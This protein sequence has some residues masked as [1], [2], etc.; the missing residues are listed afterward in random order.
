MGSTVAAPTPKTP[1]KYTDLKTP[2][3]ARGHGLQQRPRASVA[4]QRRFGAVPWTTEY[5]WVANIAQV[6]VLA[7]MILYIYAEVAVF[8]PVYHANLKSTIGSWWGVPANATMGETTPGH[9][10]MIRPT[11]FFLFCVL[12]FVVSLLLV[13]F[14]KNF[15]IRRVSSQVALKIAMVLRRKPSVGN[16]ISYWSYSEW[17]F[18][19]G[20]LVAGNMVVF[21]YNYDRRL[22]STRAKMAKKGQALTFDNYLDTISITLGFSCIYNLAFLFLPAT[23]NCAWMEFFNISYA[24]GIKYHR[25]LG[26][27]TVLTA[28]GHGFGYSWMWI[29]KKQ[30]KEHALPCFDCNVGKGKGYFV[31]FNFF[32]E[33]ALLCFLLIGITSMPL[34][35]RRFYEAFYY[36][37]HLFIVGV[38]FAVMHW[39]P[40]IWWLFPT[41]LVYVMSRC[42]SH[43]NSYTPVPIHEFSYLG[44]AIIKIVIGRSTLRD[45]HFRVGQFV[46]LNVP[47]ISKL[48]WH[49]FTIASSPRSHTTTLSILAKSLGSW[50]ENLVDYAEEC[51]KQQVLPTVY[52]DAYYGASLETYEE[53]NTICLAKLSHGEALR[54]RVFFVFSFRE[55][56]LFEEIHPLLMKIKE[57]DPQKRFFRTFLYLSYAPMDELLDRPINHSRLDGRPDLQASEYAID[58]RHKS[59]EPFAEP[60]RSR[61]MRSLTYLAL[62]FVAVVA[63][64][65]LE[66][67]GKIKAGGRGQLWLLQQF[68]EIAVLFCCALVV[69][70]FLY[71]DRVHI[72]ERA[73]RAESD[74]HFVGA[75]GPSSLDVHTF[76]DLLHEHD[77][78]LGCRPDLDAVIEEVHAAHEAFAIASGHFQAKTPIGMFMSG[79]KT[80]KRSTEFAIAAINVAAFDIHE[81]EFEFPRSGAASRAREDFLVASHRPFRS[82]SWTTRHRWTANVAQFLV[83]GALIV[84][85]YAQITFVTPLYRANL[86][87]RFDRWWGVPNNATRDDQVSGHQEMIRPTYFFLFCVLPFVV[88]LLLVEFLKNFNVRRVTSGVA[89]KMARVLRRKP[90]VGSWISY[91]SYGEWAFMWGLLVAGNIIVY[92]YFFKYRAVN[93]KAK[94][95]QGMQL[96]D[97]LAALGYN[98]IYNMAFL[99]LPATRNCAWMEFFNVSYANGIK[100]HRWLGVFTVMASL[101][102]G[103]G[104]FWMWIRKG[105]LKEQALPCFDCNIATGKGF[106]AWF[107]VFGELA[108]LCFLV[109]G[110]TSMPFIRRQCYELF[111]YVHHLFI[112]GVI[113]T[114]MHWGPIIWWLLPTLLVYIMSRCTSHANSYTP[115]LINEFT[116]LHNDIVKIV[117]SRSTLRDGHFRVGQF[118]YLNVPHISKLQWHAFTIASSPRSGSTTL[119]ILA[120]SLGNW[121]KDLVEYADECKKQNTLPTVYMDAY[122][123]ASLEMYEEYNTVCLVGGGI[124]VTPLLAILEDIVAKL[125]H[126]EALRQRVFFVFSFRELS[127]LEEIHPLLMKIKELDPQ[128]R[129]FTTHLHLTCAVTQEQLDRSINNARLGGS[130]RV[131]RT[132]VISTMSHRAPQPFAEP[133]RSRNMRSLTYVALFSVAVAVI[134]VLEYNGKIKAHG[135]DQLWPLQQFVEIVLLLCCGLVAFVFL[136]VDRAYLKERAQTGTTNDDYIALVD[137][138]GWVSDVHTFRDL[139]SQH[140]VHVGSRPAMTTIIEQVHVAHEAFAEMT[141]HMQAKTP[142]GVFVSGPE[143]LKRSTERAATEIDTAAFDIHEEAFELLNMGTAV[144][145]PTPKTPETYAVLKTPA[146][147][148]EH[149]VQQAQSSSV[150]FDR[151]FGAAPWSTKYRWAANVAPFLV[152]SAMVVY[153]YAQIAV[154]AP[155]YQ[156]NL[157]SKIGSWW[158]VPKNAKKGDPPK[159]HS[160]MIR[161][162]YFFLFCVIPLVFSLLLAEFL[163]NF[164]I[165]RVSSQVALKIAMVLRRKPR[166]GQRI[167]YWSYGEWIFALGLLVVG[168][169]LVFYYNYDR[170]NTRVRENLKKKKLPMLFN[171]YLEMISITLGFNCLYNMAFL[172]LP[173]TRNCAWMEFFNISYANGIKYHRWLGVVT[174]LTALLHC[175]GYYW[176]WIRKGQWKKQALPCFD[177]NIAKGDGF[178]AWFNVFGELA[179]I[180]FLIISVTSIPFVR[181]RFYEAFYYVHHLFIF[182]VIFAVMHWG[183]VIWWLLPTLVVYIISRS[184][185]NANSFTPVP[186][187]EFTALDNDIIKI[188][189]GRSTLRDGHFRVGQFVYLNVP[190]ISKLQWHAFTIASSPRT[191][192]TTLTILAKSLGDWTKDLVEYADECKKQHVLP[193]VYMDAFYGASLEMYEEYNT[194]CLVGGG[195]GVTPLFAILEDIVA[196]LSNGEA[197]RQR[198]F[199]IFTFR[200]L[201][202][203]EEIHPMLMKIKELDPEERYFTNRFYLTRPPTEE[204]L[205]RCIDHERLDGQPHLQAVKY[206]DKTKK[207]PL[208]FAEPLRS[209]SFR[210]MTYLGMFT[211]SIVIVVYLQYG[212]GKIEEHNERLWPLQQFVEAFLLF[213]CGVFV[214]LF[215]F[216]ERQHLKRVA[217]FQ[218]SAS[219]EFFAATATPNTHFSDVHTF[220]DLLSE[221]KVQVGSRPDMHALI[222][223]V[224]R[225]HVM[226]SEAT[227]HLQ[228]R[229][230]IGVFI[231]GPEALKTNTESASAA[232]NSADFDIHEE[233]FEL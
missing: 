19:L 205:A 163:K 201:S 2:A 181:R 148:G 55:L 56:S 79:P 116:T 229:T 124:G 198:V 52:M 102:H 73:V 135:R 227:S 17:I 13:E 95:N 157:K 220:Q 100:Y 182:A 105:E 187:K 71:V 209:R 150:A 45:G 165:R 184:T 27:F 193:T 136:Y 89:L 77:V 208:P 80:L 206:D 128:E 58:K 204:V 222:E 112:V 76:R 121:T 217:A 28:L 126:G 221:Y 164:N 127:L 195:I 16:W 34:I 200:E 211:L 177:C 98:A 166:V 110:I 38:I 133:L 42:I 41:L 210:S 188:V 213:V 72:M 144:A 74:K 67:N 1:Y 120:K 91:W 225:E 167:S 156:E 122:Y 39:G 10:E 224:H 173:A 159:G 132:E 18:M 24:N 87:L 90:R 186:V 212:G 162:T 60:L 207:T 230:P 49:G 9:Q 232:I 69:V 44:N 183:P 107:N 106:H 22:T 178:H 179:L 35:R 23:R 47:S 88:S 140:R 216:I 20:L 97:Y 12:P 93:K 103:V 143:A 117:I 228:A 130:S 46:Y 215:I 86:R 83:I 139:L 66:F 53:Y 111:Y 233:E 172:F 170:R 7:I 196:K 26:V 226:F 40:I 68:V 194:I 134:I 115:V 92:C 109:I 175:I 54:Q 191:N 145:T 15:N 48:Q 158:G 31:W 70:A 14:L 218:N 21:Y 174:V 78:Q 155:V 202:L 85:I 141:T 37:H 3:S 11:Y 8:T 154:F 118:V 5:R 59:V 119:T 123:G 180:C 176:M 61:K 6:L 219:D 51:N 30:W 32:G 192:G 189:V 171:N 168:N 131:Q 138:F 94:F 99:F 36:V 81:E 197:L 199:F 84:Y 160:E 203:L 104:F 29:R 33:I 57:L 108:L 43:A 101:L 185:S 137:G 113:F 62:F 125:S 82:A 63:V 214:L 149:G 65:V 151:R 75:G 50:T 147:A 64:I 190:S 169:I 161:P 114:I 153:I 152:L 4:F 146:A 231:S 223:E 142:I 96:H 25:W 129:F